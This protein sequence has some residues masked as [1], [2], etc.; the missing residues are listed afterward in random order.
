MRRASKSTRKRHRHRHQ[1]IALGMLLTGGCGARPYVP[2]PKRA[3]M[4][5]LVR[6]EP[7]AFKFLSSRDGPPRFA[8]VTEGIYRGGQPSAGHL[9]ALY[10]LGV[11]TVIN[12]RREDAE[13]WQQEERQARALGMA[14]MHYPF[15][16]IFGADERFL[17]G[18]VEQMK[19]GAVYVHCKH[20]RDRTSLLVALYRV[21]VESWEPRLAW[22]LEA[23]D[24]GSAQTYFYRQLRIVF[25]RMV[26]RHPPALA[27]GDDPLDSGG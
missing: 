17:Q 19:A 8:R 3:S 1:I 26:K 6:D 13:A 12:L 20:G 2:A 15:Y 7:E 27:G 21:L 23:I 25:D 5:D 10:A 14:F 4:M 11:R 24:Y 22:R 18:I 9:E 16:G